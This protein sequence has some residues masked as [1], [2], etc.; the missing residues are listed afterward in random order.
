MLFTLVREKV[1]DQTETVIFDV[2]ANVGEFSA[3][4]FKS[5]GS[6]IKIHAFEP[7]QNIC[8]QLSSR[9][10]GNDHIVINNLALGREAGELPLYGTSRDTGMA[11]LLPRNLDHVGLSSSFQEIVKVTRLADY[12]E[13]QGLAQ[14]HLL[15]MDV[16]GYE[17]EVLAGAESLFA[18]GKVLMCSFEFGGC[19]LDARTFL[20]DFF[21]FFN[22][23][24]MQIHR[25]TP[26]STLVKIPRYSE[27]LERFTT[28][29]YVAL[30][31]NWD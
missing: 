16:E 5:L 1:R 24:K 2:G 15:K 31:E 13:S 7:S 21:E 8:E 20:R 9:F 11:S 12:C 18:N 25:I 10:A 6:G 26:A 14:I 22:R 29:N 23:H 27:N 28:T 30:S 19:N 3:V 17:L 4:A